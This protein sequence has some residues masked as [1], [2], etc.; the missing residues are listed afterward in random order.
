MALTAHAIKGAAGYA[1]AQAIGDQAK[2]LESDAKNGV[3]LDALAV[4]FEALTASMAG[5]PEA[6]A[7][8]LAAQFGTA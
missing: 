2:A 6:I 1:G 8:S 4:R 5:L 7:A 3:A